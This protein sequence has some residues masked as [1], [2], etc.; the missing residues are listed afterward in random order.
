V[1]DPITTYE[2]LS[3]DVAEVYVMALDSDRAT[4]DGSFWDGPEVWTAIGWQA[5]DCQVRGA[6]WAEGADRAVGVLS[7]A[8]GG[9]WGLELYD[10][11]RTMDPSNPTGYLGRY[12]QPGRY[13]RFGYQGGTIGTGVIDSIVYEPV[14]GLARLRGTDGVGLGAQLEIDPPSASVDHL[15]ELARYVLTQIQSAMV[16]CEP[17]PPAG[18]ELI[19]S[20]VVLPTGKIKAWA[21]VADAARD[22][23]QFAWIDRDLILRFRPHADPRD[24]G[25][26]LGCDG[27]PTLGLIVSATG[28]GILNTVVAKP[29][30]GGPTVTVSDA[31]SIRRY[32]VRKLDRSDRQVPNAATWAPA[33]LLDRAWASMELLPLQSWPTAA[34]GLAQLDAVFGA[35]MIANVRIRG[36]TVDPPLSID[37]RLIARGAKVSAEGWTID[38]L[39]YLTDREWAAIPLPAPEPPD[40]M[41]ASQLVTRQTILDRVARV[42]HDGVTATGVGAEAAALVGTLTGLDRSRVVMGWTTAPVLADVLELVRA[43]L[44]I[45]TPPYFTPGT[46]WEPA[47]GNNLW[48]DPSAIWVGPLPA[49]TRPRIR[50]RRLTEAFTEGTQTTPSAANAV[51][52]PGPGSSAIN[53]QER[54]VPQGGSVPIDLDVTEVVRLWTPILGG[55]HGQLAHGFAVWSQDDS[56]PQRAAAIATDDAVAALRPTLTIEARIPA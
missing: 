54:D 26:Q 31:E 19:G 15:R 36:D 1:T 42:R 46:L 24:P 55:G 2:R 33:V 13:I 17:D 16:T 29:T 14:T 6:E 56:D 28:D 43:T 47:A 22:A 25:I 3:A 50:I 49:T 23:L 48:G 20:P 10:P 45:W 30:G 27:I 39:A 41:P 8:T 37:A 34:D 38:V 9:S 7:S 51:I 35:P 52:W 44:R 21:A 53:E 5:I 18:D 32:G 11:D 40:P 4:W 12:V